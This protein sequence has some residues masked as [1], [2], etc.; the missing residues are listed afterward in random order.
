MGKM[1]NIKTLFLGLF[2]AFL[3]FGY[4]APL[5]L[6]ANDICTG[7][8][9]TAQ[10]AI[11]CGSNNASGQTGGPKDAAGSLNNAITNIINILSLIVGIVAV[12]M[13]VVAGF[14]YITSAGNDQAVA[15]AKKTLLYA[16]IGLIIVALAQV[17][18]KF[19]L[20]RATNQKP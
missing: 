17:I 20:N 5:A 19:V 10:Q 6:A 1:K 14:R 15:G 13:I 18:V 12:I 2:S 4:S 3:V 16:V 8:N 7:T 11:E 9:L